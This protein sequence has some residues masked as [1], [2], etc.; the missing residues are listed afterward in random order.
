VSTYAT[1]ALIIVC[2]TNTIRV[3]MVTE[4]RYKSQHLSYI[5]V[6][7][8]YD[9]FPNDK[10]QEVGKIRDTLRLLQKEFELKSFN[11]KIVF[12]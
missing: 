1:L 4:L 3:D 2:Y 9:I 6:F 12:D 5:K 7:P 10:V 11:G 8:C